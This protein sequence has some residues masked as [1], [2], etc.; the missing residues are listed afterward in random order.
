MRLSRSF[1]PLMAQPEYSWATGTAS[2]RCAISAFWGRLS[3]FG[4][5]VDPVSDHSKWAA[6]IE[7]TQGHKANYPLIG[8]PE[9]KICRTPAD[10]A[11][12]RT[13]FVIGPDK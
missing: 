5:S 3:Q 10:N 2:P 6:D 13:A 7:E 1:V 11:T 4:L 8:D 12:V 9:L